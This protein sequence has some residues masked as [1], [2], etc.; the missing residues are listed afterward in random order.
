M[1]AATPAESIRTAFACGVLAL[2]VCLTTIYATPG[3]AYWIVD[4]GAKA[5]ISRRLLES[6]Y[7]Q[8]DLGYPAA[9]LDPEGGAFP[10]PPPFAVR[11]GDGFVS[12]YPPA[13]P[14]LA[15]PFLAVLGERGLRLPAALGNAA[16]AWLFAFWIA[17]VLG[18]RWAFAGGLFLAL[19]TPLYFYGVT[20]WEH[21]LCVALP[22]AA[23][24]LLARPGRWRLVAAGALVAAACWLRAELALMGLAIAAACVARGR[25]WA[26]VA[27]L[28]LGAAPLVAALLAFNAGVYGSP[29]GPH[30]SGNVGMP[31]AAG[32]GGFAAL[33]RDAGALLAAYGGGPREGALLFGALVA[34]LVGGALAARR[35]RATAAVTNIALAVGVV[36]SLLGSLRISQAAVPFHT[37]PYYNGLM[38][39]A[40]VICLAGIG[41]VQVWRRRE[42]A[43]LR[44][45]V[46]AGLLF[47]ALGA[48]LRV[49]LTDFSSGGHWG[50]RMLLP[51]MPALVALGI[52]ALRSGL[53]VA[54]GPLRRLTAATAMAL[55]LACLA[56]SGVATWLLDRQKREVRELQTAILSAPQEV[57]V[58]NYPALGQQL[59]AIWGRKPMLL[60]GGESVGRVLAAAR[61]NGLEEFLFLHR[62]PTGRSLGRIPGAHCSLAGQHRGRYAPVVFDLDLQSC[63]TLPRARR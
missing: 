54:R 32:P 56:S 38:L 27:A 16:C 24:V 4:S 28:A 18:R 29:L 5:L 45:G 3:D 35:E 10:I 57:V 51:A 26:D 9:D 40:P 20:V 60:V 34:C 13:Y 14:A 63:T 52:A 47:L 17:P 37:L 21:S 30:L 22:L 50:P 44:L 11:R 61:R 49:L 31:E 46:G 42:Y 15:A 12:Q 48:A 33:M 59:A 58:T 41:V 2:G 43:A 19:A 7:A 6:G 23:C 39:Q 8:L 62:P 55:A 53:G 36:A 1:R 25:R